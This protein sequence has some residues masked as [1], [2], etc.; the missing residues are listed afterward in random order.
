MESDQADILVAISSFFE[1]NNIPYMITGA[2]SVIYYGR[3][4]ASHDIDFVIDMRQKD[5]SRLYSALK[6]MKNQYV[7]EKTSIE[8][9]FHHRDLFQLV[10]RGTLLKI[11]CWL[12]H[13]DAFDQSRFKRKQRI[14]AFGQQIWIASA[15]DTILQKLRWY[16]EAKI[17]RHLN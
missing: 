12:L 5:V 3:P 13:D 10:H 6:K 8:R 1:K 14:Q 15:E 7:F 11:D 4:R 16:K 2:W 9:A 17:E